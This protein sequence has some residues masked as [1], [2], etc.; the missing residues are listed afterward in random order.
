[1]SAIS[2]IFLSA[3]LALVCC[4]EAGAREP[5][6]KGP[7]DPKVLA[8]DGPEPP[9]KLRRRVGLRNIKGKGMGLLDLR[10]WPPEPPSPAEVDNKRLAKALARL[11]RDW[12]PPKRPYRYA[13]W[14]IT[15]SRQFGVDPF[16]LASLIYRQSRCLPRRREA[17]GVGLAMIN[18]RMHGRYITKR[19]YQ[20][21]VLEK[22]ESESTWKEHGLDLKEFAFVRGNLRRAKRNIYFAAALLSMHKRQCPANDGAFGSVPHRHYVSH[23]TWGDQVK[24]AGAE[25]RILRSRRRLLDYYHARPLAEAKGKFGDLPLHCP[26]EAPPRKVTSGMGRDREG[27]K[28]RH[29]GLDFASTGGEPV[30]AV[31]DGLVYMAGMDQKTGGAINVEPEEAATIK[32]SQMGPG[33]LLVMMRHRGGLVSAYMHLSAYIVRYRQKVKAG[34]IIGFVGKTGIKDSGAHLHFE[35]RHKGK[36][37]D[38]LPHLKPYVFEP[39]QC[40]RGWRVVLEERRVRRKRRVKRWQ[41]YKAKLLKDRGAIK[42]QPRKRKRP[43]E[44]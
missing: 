10:L 29:M 39:L 43:S 2:K 21:W 34:E 17:Y 15:Y 7:T 26:L 22:G 36:H 33:G 44:K 16:L 24:G 23:F 37:V 6:K 13:D 1:M 14:I 41:D 28:R 12:M 35:L 40:Y 27:G 11:C 32:P 5:L 42:R 9:F 3:C 19:R 31:A 18:H 20:Y 38:P 25:D 30:L 8:Y 4:P